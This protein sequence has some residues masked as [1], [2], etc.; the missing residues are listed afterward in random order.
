M[1]S[2][3]KI[4]LLALVIFLSGCAGGSAPSLIEHNEELARKNP[5]NADA[6]RGLGRTVG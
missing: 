4:S 1:F 3:A 5:N 6:H 2:N